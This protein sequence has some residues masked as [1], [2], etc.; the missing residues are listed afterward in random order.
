MKK[1]FIAIAAV[2]AVSFASC[3]GNAQQAEECDS[4]SCTE[5]VVEEV[6]EETEAVAD[7]LTEVVDTLAEVA[8]EV[9][10]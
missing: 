9:A 1:I 6:A 8:E 7:T 2:V 3:G 10:E 4:T 5:E